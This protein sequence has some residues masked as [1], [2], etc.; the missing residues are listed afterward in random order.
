MFGLDSVH[1][2]VS[3]RK[4]VTKSN[5]VTVCPHN[6]IELSPLFATESKCLLTT[7]IRSTQ[8]LTGF[9]LVSV[10]DILYCGGGNKL[11]IFSI[12][13]IIHHQSQKRFFHCHR[14]LIVDRI[15]KI[16]FSFL[17]SVFQDETDIILL[18]HQFPCVGSGT[19]GHQYRQQQHRCVQ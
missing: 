7:F 12:F 15:A 10:I 13:A 3:F 17:L 18:R 14:V 8:L 9:Q 1:P 5:S 4:S 6:K 19:G 16:H 2:S 11:R